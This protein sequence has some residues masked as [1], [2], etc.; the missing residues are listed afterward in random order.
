M[1]KHY[2]KFLHPG[3]LFPNESVIEIKDRNEYFDVPESAFAY[4]FFDREEAVVDGERLIGEDKNVSGKII[5]GDVWTIDD[6]RANM[7]DNRTLIFNME[8]NDYPVV[9]RTRHG[10]FYPVSDRDCVIADAEE[11]ADKKLQTVKA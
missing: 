5:I 8:A 9:C 4:Y 11:L 7:P 10:N 2:V 1:T 6:V 3:T